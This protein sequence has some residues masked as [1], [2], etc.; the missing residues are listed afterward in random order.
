LLLFNCPLNYTFLVIRSNFYSYLSNNLI[1]IP[2]A[3]DLKKNECN[4]EKGRV[5]LEKK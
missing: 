2:E 3:K 4:K 5:S 1:E